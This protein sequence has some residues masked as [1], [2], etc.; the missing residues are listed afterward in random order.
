LINPPIKP[1][2]QSQA[3]LANSLLTGLSESVRKSVTPWL[4]D[5]NTRQLV[6]AL[7]AY[8]FV[9]NFPKEF[10]GPYEKALKEK[11]NGLIACDSPVDVVGLQQIALYAWFSELSQYAPGLVSSEDLKAGYAA[12]LSFIK[13]Y[14]EYVKNVYGEAVDTASLKREEEQ[15]LLA[16]EGSISN[17]LKYGEPLFPALSN[18]LEARANDFEYTLARALNS[19][20]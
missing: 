15:I 17:F 20:S 5:K 10:A 9:R 7:T 8:Q 11:Y 19:S 13:I 12:I 16:E 18:V 3:D 6:R 14:K 1:P 4:E 2:R